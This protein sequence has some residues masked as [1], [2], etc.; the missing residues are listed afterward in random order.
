MHIQN[1][2]E[3]TLCTCPISFFFQID[4]DLEAS[5]ECNMQQYEGCI[6]PSDGLWVE[7]SD[8]HKWSHSQCVASI[9]VF[10]KKHT[11]LVATQV[12]AAIVMYMDTST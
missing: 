1:E 3:C 9:T 10:S 11:F 12:I 6:N 2:E 5:E 7:C 4:D 8:C